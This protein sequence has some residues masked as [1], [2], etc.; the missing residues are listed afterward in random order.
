MKGLVRESKKNSSSSKA[1]VSFRIK[2]IYGIG[3]ITNTIKTI[4]FGIFTLYFYTT[5]LGLSGTLVGIASAAGLV[6]DAIIDPVIGRYSD[7][8]QGRLGKRHGL[9]LT[10]SAGMGIA[11]WAYFSP[12]GNLSTP[13]LFSWLLITS[14][15][16]RTM[17]SLF[18]IPYFALG[19]E[20][21]RDYHER[22]SV[23]GFRSFFALLGTLAAATLSFVLFFP[24]TSPGIDPKFNPEGYRAMGLW[25]G[26]AMTLIGCIC[27]LGTLPYR[28]YYAPKADMPEK[29][30]VRSFFAD[31]LRSLRNRSFR[32][33]F[34]SYAVFFLGTVLNA[35]IA[36]H[37]LTYYVKI[38]ES[39]ALS[40]FQLSFY[41]GAL[42]GVL[43]WIKISKHLEK[44]LIYFFGTL[45]TA[46]IMGCAF[47]LLGEGHLLG[48]GNLQPLLIG[49]GVAGFFAS[50]LWIIPG[51]MIADIADQDELQTGRRREGVFFGL[52]N[53]GEQMAAGVSILITG[54]LLDRF[55]GLVPGQTQQSVLT[56]SRIGM[57]YSL[58]PSALLAASAV[59]IL[60]YS[61]NH[62]VIT[63]TQAQLKKNAHEKSP[64]SLR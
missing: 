60:K 31:M 52:F 46:I 32:S 21:T 4:L 20:L 15:C 5:V 13:A 27:T 38:T 1:K 59:T 2:I 45:A 55:T 9:M 51:S 64:D 8:L 62:S 61:I 12:P 36:I 17:T 28:Q 48:T 42:A 3:Q 37:F 63:A 40:F 47:F 10:G 11:F 25:A 57:L 33:I 49:Q 50:V 24:A 26:L 22:T 44:S 54:V 16:V 18:A 23:T 14:L 56:I 29:E 43:F 41:L 6:W 34:I 7:T 58:L 39:K 53:F 30:T 19:A 35:T